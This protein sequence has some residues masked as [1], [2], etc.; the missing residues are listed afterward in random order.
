[1]PPQILGTQ[2]PLLAG[3]GVAILRDGP[4]AFRAIFAAIAGAKTQIDIEYFI[5][6]DV[7]SDGLVLGDLLAAKLR[8]GV[9]VN[10]IY[11]SY[12]ASGTPAEFFTRMR[13]A[14]ANLVDFN[15]INP[16]EAGGS[17]A[18]DHR[19]HRKILVVDGAIAIIGGV[20]L[21]TDYESNPLARSNPR[22]GPATQA[23]GVATT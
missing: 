16:L 5:L 19:D 4:V 11:D 8:D 3:N 2:G 15:P 6:E 17:Y 1:M 18:P 22:T 20:N 7:T 10:L 14:G 9:A 21:S 23:D 13:Q 12:G